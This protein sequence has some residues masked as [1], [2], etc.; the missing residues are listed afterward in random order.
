MEKEI[1]REARKQYCHYFRFWFILLGVLAVIFIV[2]F[3][4][5]AVRPEVSRTNHDA[6]EER[7]YDYAGVLT[8]EEEEKLRDYI[9]MKEA[10]YHFDIVLVT[11]RE[12]VERIGKWNTVM[13]NTADD[14]WDKNRYGYNKGFEGDGVLLLDNWYTDKNGSQKG[15]WLSTSGRVYERFSTS[16]IARVKDAVNALADDDPYKAYKAY[17]DTACRLMGSTSGIRIPGIAILGLPLVIAAVYL[18]SHMQQ[19]PAK[20]TTTATEYVSGGRPVMRASSD[21]FIRKNV[22]SRRI[23]T[24]SGGGGSSG[25][26]GSHRSSSGARHGGGGGRR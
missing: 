22:V 9:A 19:K 20:D 25:R 24:S 1:K 21:D 26:G 17:V 5:Q 12:D 6:P 23:E 18:I 15:N 13:M 14:F 2:T 4:L 3:I 7:V 8:D 16:D 10:R 11:M